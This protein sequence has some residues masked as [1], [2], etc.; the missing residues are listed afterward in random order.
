MKSCR[1]PL[2]CTHC[3][4]YGHTSNVCFKKQAEDEGGEEEDKAKPKEAKP[5][6]VEEK[7][8]KTDTKCAPFI[9]CNGL[10]YQVVVK[11]VEVS[12]EGR[13]LQR[14]VET[15]TPLARSEVRKAPRQS[16]MLILLF[17]Y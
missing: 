5:A 1:H 13:V 10:F 12:E 3:R 6:A 7:E 9:Q 14:T 17:S 8:G 16:L 11:L 4:R 2:F 15:G